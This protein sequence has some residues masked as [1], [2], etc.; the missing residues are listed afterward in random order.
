MSIVRKSAQGARDASDNQHPMPRDG[1]RHSSVGLQTPTCGSAVGG[2]YRLIRLLGRGAMGSVYQAEDQFQRRCCAVKMLNNAGSCS[3]DE[4]RRFHNEATAISRLSHPNIV[5]IYDFLKDAHGRSYLVMELLDGVDLFAYQQAEGRLTL[6]RAQEIIGPVAEALYSAHR[7]GIIHRDIKPRNIFLSQQLGFNGPTEVVKVVDFGLAKVQSHLHQQT[8]QGIILGTPEYLSP[9]ATLGRTDEVDARSD[10][11]ALAVTAYRLLSGCLPYEEDDVIQLLLKIRMCTPRPLRELAPDLPA[12]AEQAIARA[13]SQKKEDRFP[14]IRAFAEAFVG[15]TLGSL[16]NHASTLS[17][18]SFTTHPAQQA[19]GSCL[20]EPTVPIAAALLNTL[21]T[22]TESSRA[23]M[24]SAQSIP[25]PA[26][27]TAERNR[28]A[29]NAAI[30]MKRL[31]LPCAGRPAT[32][33]SWL[34]RM[35]VL[36]LAPLFLLSGPPDLPAEERKTLAADSVNPAPKA[37]VA[38]ALNYAECALSRASPA[39]RNEMARPHTHTLPASSSPSPIRREAVPQRSR[40][41][42]P[43][44]HAGS[45]ATSAVSVVAASGSA[46]DITSSAASTGGAPAMRVQIVDDGDTSTR[47]GKSTMDARVQDASVTRPLA[48]SPSNQMGP[49]AVPQSLNGGS[50]HRIAGMDPK[51]PP[52]VLSAL[53]GERLSATYKVCVNQLGY[54]DA[55]APLRGLPMGDDAVLTAVRTWRYLPMKARSCMVL[56]LPFEISK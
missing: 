30:Q 19:T 37:G 10:Q 39:E 7:R 49:P 22:Q 25:A 21:L 23:D 41:P 28:E 48:T 12:Y 43:R 55:V 4:L 47:D 13:L 34:H 46:T 33:P 20:D 51:L 1:I 11:W 15:P 3:A 54:V 27:K 32:P 2:R 6:R 38:N 50:M 17:V 45:R 29:T 31:A 14:D 56:E 42:L 8:A 18:P 40:R 9:E 5:Q 16:A 44:V 26:P 53:R 52:F 35:R 36:F 24:S